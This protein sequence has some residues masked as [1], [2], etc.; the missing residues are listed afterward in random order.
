[1]HISPGSCR[2]STDSRAPEQL[3]QTDSASAVIFQVW[4]QIPSATTLQS[5]QN[6][7]I[8]ISNKFPA[9]ADADADA[10]GPGTILWEPLT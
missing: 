10:A 8:C 9:D 7:K 5:S 1:M 2:S 4:G 6:P 3:H